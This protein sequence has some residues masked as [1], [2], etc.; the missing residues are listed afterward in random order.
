MHCVRNKV[1]VVR[2]TCKAKSLAVE[3]E[4]RRCEV[5]IFDIENKKTETLKKKKEKKEK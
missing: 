5:E 2:K 3:K 1:E 4:N